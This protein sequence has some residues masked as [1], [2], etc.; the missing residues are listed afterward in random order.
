MCLG[1]YANDEGT[2]EYQ[3]MDLKANKQKTWYMSKKI[4][5]FIYFVSLWV[6][7]S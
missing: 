5:N 4:L 3:V 1:T 2:N 7:F 6:C